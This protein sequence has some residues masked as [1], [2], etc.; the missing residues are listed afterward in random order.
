MN[1]QLTVFRHENVDVVD[2]REVANMIGRNHKELLRDI[3][4]YAEILT[5]ATERNFALSDFFIP[6]NYT[7]PTNR[8]LPCY[9][10]T[11]KGCDMVANKM[12]G[13]KGVIFT[14]AYVTAFEQM[15]QCIGS[16]IPNKPLSMPEYLL[17]QAQMMVEQE[18]KIRQLTELGERNT[19]AIRSIGSALNVPTIDRDQWQQDMNSFISKLSLDYSIPHQTAYGDLYGALEDKTGC[20]LEARQRNMRRRLEQQGA[21]YKE[22]QK[23]TKLSAIAV[24][25]NLRTTFEALV[26]KYAAHLAAKKWGQ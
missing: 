20:D 26:Q 3:R 6:G 23:I 7:D 8:T 5:K 24:D 14:A 12:T 15:R 16:G 4:N 13:E 25:S 21:P 22:R 2:S 18:K 1:E 19:E 11:K 9:Y 10:L 17:A